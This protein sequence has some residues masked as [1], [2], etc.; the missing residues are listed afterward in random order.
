MHGGK[1]WHIKFMYC[2]IGLIG[3]PEN[4]KGSVESKLHSP[5]PGHQLPELLQDRIFHRDTV[6]GCW[7]L[8]RRI[9][10]VWQGAE[11]VHFNAHVGALTPM[12]ATFSEAEPAQHRTTVR[13]AGSLHTSVFEITFAKW[14]DTSP[15]K[16]TPA[17]QK[18]NPR[19]KI[20]AKR[21]TTRKDNIQENKN[22]PTKYWRRIHPKPNIQ[23]P[24]ML[25]LRNKSAIFTS[26]I[27]NP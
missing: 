27:R 12:T 8:E 11:L 2:R 9:P 16:S 19:L 7:S 20:Q 13:K 25:S 5:A 1:Q 21:S 24:L 22:Q 14:V 17:G 10:G 3:N 15:Y 23:M 18:A 4:K 26:T 6:S